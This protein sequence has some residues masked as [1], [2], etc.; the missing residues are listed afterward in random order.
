M[1]IIQTKK[2]WKKE[3]KK[4]LK[5]NIKQHFR[6]TINRYLMELINYYELWCA[7]ETWTWRREV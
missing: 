5:E 1:K 6:V 3:K 7:G 2:M 4:N